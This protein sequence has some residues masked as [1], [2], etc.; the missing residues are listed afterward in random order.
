MTSALIFLIRTIADL[1][2]LMF[3]LRFIL[4]WVRASYRNPLSQLVQKVT[5]PLVV[6]AR[7]VL[8][9]VAG[10]DLPTL[11]VLIVL[12][13]LVTFLL[14]VIVHYP[15]SI[16]GLLFLVALRL[17]SLTLWFYSVALFVYVLLSWFGDRS[18]GPMGSVLAEIVEPLLRPVRRLVPPI[19]GLDLSALLVMLV[20]QAGLIALA[21]PPFLR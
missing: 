14:L 21:L 5:S 2:L 9:S 7:R 20:F 13:S 16:S 19:A 10:L 6:P 3:L 8:P 11:V 4:Q 18:G 12:E 17:V 15:L 1:Y